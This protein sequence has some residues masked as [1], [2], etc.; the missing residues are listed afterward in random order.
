[1]TIRKAAA[2]ITALAAFSASTMAQ[3][4]VLEEIIVT[5]TKRT[6][7]L[8]DIPVTVNALSATTIQEAGIHNLDD[9]AVLVPTL[10]VETNL[11]PFT[12]AIRIRGFGTSQIDPSLEASVAFILD[13]VYMGSSGLGMSEL[14]DVERIEVLQG[15]QG[16][17]FGKNSNAGVV[18]VIT[19]SPNTENTEGFVEAS[20]GDYSMKKVMASITGPINDTMAYSLGGGWHEYDGW[21]ESDSGNDLNGADDWNVRGKFLWQPTDVLSIQLTGSHVDRDTSCCAADATQT[22]AVTD[23][24]VLKGLPVPKNDAFDYKNNVDI[25]SNFDLKADAINVSVDYEM[26]NASF[27]SL[28]AWNDYKYHNSYDVERSDLSVLG[29]DDQVQTGELW[30]QEFRLTSELS[31][32]WQYMTGLFYAYEERTRGDGSNVAVI[33]E[34]MI[35]VGG[36]AVGIG[37]A[38]G[39]IV[40]PGDTVSFNDKWETE[41]YAVFGQT[42]YRLG[43]AWLATLGLRYTHETKDADLNTQPFSTAPLFGTGL[44]FIERAFAAVDNTFNLDSDAWNGLANISYF[45]DE[46]DIMLFASVSTGSK[47]GGFNG[48]AGEVADRTYDDEDT[49][50]YELGLKSQ[51]LDNRLQINAS[52]FYTEFDDLQFLT[53]QP[54]GVGFIVTNAAEATSSGVDISVAAR[55][56]NFL[57]LDGGVQYLDAEYTEGALDEGG[58]DVPNA[59]DWSGV[60]SATF[61]LPLGDG[62]TYLRGDYSYMS[63]HFTNPTYQPKETEQDRTLVNVR[64]GWR[65][66]Q[67]DATL[68]VKNATDEAYSS[69]AAEPLAFSGTKTQFLTAPRTYGA[70]LRYS[71]GN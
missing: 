25:D 5:A 8:Q 66:D 3:Q 49:T 26:A 52:I 23:Q 2:S 71:F 6:E 56:W 17:L 32:P 64:L 33:G 11:N 41:T 63:D 50:N 69:A 51:F 48:S 39:V 12:T 10:T 14:T 40:Q 67:W 7:N 9:V 62:V 47:S 54:S 18:S 46:K 15:P 34:D 61:L 60:L 59:P 27:K 53:S 16:T 28:T 4:A 42:S 58:F 29:V 43:E 22:S 37:P 13:G 55:P 31:G 57:M 70:T 35:P 36:A 44:S 24:L 1:M 38:F 68:W 65:N 20:A 21:L 19:R 45:L 30:S